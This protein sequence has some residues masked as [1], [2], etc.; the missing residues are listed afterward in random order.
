MAESGEPNLALAT[1]LVTDLLMH[2]Q[3][4]RVLLYDTVDKNPFGVVHPRSAAEQKQDSI[5]RTLP[6]PKYLRGLVTTIN[7]GSPQQKLALL[8]EFYSQSFEDHITWPETSSLLRAHSR[9][10]QVW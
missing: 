4:V 6:F 9:A 10:P 8:C 5:V 7:E 1:E 3:Y 2:F